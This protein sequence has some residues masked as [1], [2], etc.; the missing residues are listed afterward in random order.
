VH[1]TTE[2]DAAQA[3][4]TDRVCNLAGL[5]FLL[6]HFG[7]EYAGPAERPD[8]N[9]M[10]MMIREVGKLG[11]RLTDD[12]FEPIDDLSQQLVAATTFTEPEEVAP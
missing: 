9:D 10:G 5:F 2:T 1:E 4:A 7:P 3:N 11:A 12:A 6:R 8:M